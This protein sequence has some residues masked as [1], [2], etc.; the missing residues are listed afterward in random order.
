MKVHHYSLNYANVSQSD[1][2]I[3]QFACIWH[4]YKYC[5]NKLLKLLA[6]YIPI[7]NLKIIHIIIY[8]KSQ[9]VLT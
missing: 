4:L 7:H 6:L 9:K 5:T 8:D 2:V 1:S 3:L